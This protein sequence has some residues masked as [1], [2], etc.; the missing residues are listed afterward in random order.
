MIDETKKRLESR[1][2][3][4]LHVRFGVGVKVQSLGLHHVKVESRPPARRRVTDPGRCLRGE[5]AT[6]VLKTTAAAWRT[7]QTTLAHRLF[8]CLRWQLRM[9]S[10]VLRLA[11][12]RR[13]THSNPGTPMPPRY[14]HVCSHQGMDGCERCGTCTPPPSRSGTNVG[15]LHQRSLAVV[16][17]PI[18]IT[19]RRA[20][21]DRRRRVQ[22]ALVQ[23]D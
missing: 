20:T 18:P 5:H 6:S 17:W 4:K 12:H 11:V 10:R 15:T 7:F 1:M 16:R 14:R 23:V 8:L 2:L 22:V 21:P 19:P 3:R 13:R 9:L